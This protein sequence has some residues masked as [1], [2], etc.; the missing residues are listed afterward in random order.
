MTRKNVEK[1]TFPRSKR[2][3]HFLRQSGELVKLA[4]ARSA[5]FRV[6]ASVA[7]YNC[8]H[9]RS[10]WAI[11]CKAYL[12]VKVCKTWKMTAKGANW[13]SINEFFPS[14]CSSIFVLEQDVDW[15]TLHA[16]GNRTADIE[17]NNAG[18]ND[19][20]RREWRGPIKLWV[21]CAKKASR[22][23]MWDSH[24]FEVF[25]YFLRGWQGWAWRQQQ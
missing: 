25:I 20:F 1:L 21:Y 10:S 3:W 11:S 16:R 4:S 17:C 2:Y 23:E 7:S 24:I 22:Q 18:S 19:H 12:R 14:T 13:C 6:A 8:L 5:A 9:R 15:R